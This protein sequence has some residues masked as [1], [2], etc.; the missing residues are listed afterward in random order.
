MKTKYIRLLTYDQACEVIDF[1]NAQEGDAYA[2]ITTGGVSVQSED[3][4]PIESFLEDKGF[5]H[6]WVEEP[7]HRV[8]A[9]IIE[10]LKE[11]GIIN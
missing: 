11:Q 8:T 3:F 2:N 9:R 6:E 5:R 4:E 10:D 1:T 7:P